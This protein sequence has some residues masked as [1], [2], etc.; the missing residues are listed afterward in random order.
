MAGG[1]SAYASLQ[2]FDKRTNNQ[3]QTTLFSSLPQFAELAPSRIMFDGAHWQST[4]AVT[5]SGIQTNRYDFSVKVRHPDGT[6]HDTTYIV[7]P[8][9]EHA[10]H[11]NPGTTIHSPDYSRLPPQMRPKLGIDPLPPTRSSAQSGLFYPSSYPCEY[12]RDLNAIIEDVDPDPATAHEIA[13]LDTL[14]Q[15]SGIVILNDPDPVD[16]IKRAPTMTYYHGNTAHQFVFT[17]FSIWSYARQ[18]CMGLVDFV[19]QDLWHLP[20][21][22]IDRGS[23]TPAIRNGVTR[24]ARVVTPAQRAVTAR[25]P[26]GATRE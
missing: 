7:A 10:D 26:S 9:W 22:A 11:F 5:K 23:I 1:G 24:P 16:G 25:V 2:L 20:R 17:G 14:Y 12:I 19:L 4:V 3:G 13:V 21:T 15:A 18:D 6:D 8:A